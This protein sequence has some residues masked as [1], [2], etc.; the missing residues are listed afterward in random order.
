MLGII[1]CNYNLAKLFKYPQDGKLSSHW[2]ARQMQTS[3]MTSEAIEVIDL[4]DTQPRAV[5]VLYV[6][7]NFCYSC[8]L[9]ICFYLLLK[10]N[11]NSI[12]I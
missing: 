6:L 7:F 3:I 10:C 2:D 8:K 12:L 1:F 9:I 11:F 5:I 4:L